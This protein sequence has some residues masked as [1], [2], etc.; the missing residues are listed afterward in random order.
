MR[1]GEPIELH[2]V[3]HAINP[4][5][6][7][8]RL[9]PDLVPFFEEQEALRYANYNLKQWREIDWFERAIHVAHF[10]YK[11]LIELHSNDA[12]SNKMESEQAK[13]KK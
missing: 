13:R 7:Y 10:R 8:D 6:T 1:N 2:Y 9:A 5:I 3:K 12:V 11:K 4:G